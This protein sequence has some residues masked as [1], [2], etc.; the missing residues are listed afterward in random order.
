MNCQYCG[1]PIRE[2]DNI[3]QNCGRQT[4]R[5]ANKGKK[6][7]VGFLAVYFGSGIIFF[8]V[9]VVII[10]F[11]I[12]GWQYSGHIHSEKE[13]TNY[14]DNLDCT[15]NKKEQLCNLKG[16]Y[17]IVSTKDGADKIG[18]TKTMTFKI[19][20]TNLTFDV[21]SAYHCKDS[22]DGSCFGYQYRLSDN[23]KMKDKEYYVIEYNR[24]IGYN[25]QFCYSYNDSKCYELD[26]TIK[27]QADL[28]YVFDYIKGFIDY[29][30]K[31]DIKIIDGYYD[32]ISIY[33]DIDGDKYTYR[34]WDK[35]QPSDGTMETYVK[36]YLTD[37][38]IEL[39]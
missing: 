14:V 5:G 32:S 24:T 4:Y 19:K 10:I 12:R 16:K 1:S 28:K 9:I 38:G 13:F 3:C 37:K 8:I 29:V 17:E 27:S 39:K 36:N 11:A 2:T 31:L 33:F 26:F 18:K 7:A 25:D 15:V 20:N 6:A 30:N 23:Y 35:Y 34:F 22:I 21:V